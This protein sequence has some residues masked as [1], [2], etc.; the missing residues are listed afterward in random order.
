MAEKHLGRKFYDYCPKGCKGVQL[1]SRYC[2]HLEKKLP[3]LKKTKSVDARAVG[4]RIEQ[5]HQSIEYPKTPVDRAELELKLVK[6]GLNE[7]EVEL[8]VGRVVDGRKLEDFGWTS[9]GSVRYHLKRLFKVL[10]E[11]GFK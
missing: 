1:G 9:E 5:A 6:I 10:K 3:S 2:F 8:V 7:W 4:Q 11:R